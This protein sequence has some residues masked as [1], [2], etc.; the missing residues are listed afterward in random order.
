[1]S[2]LDLSKFLTESTSPHQALIAQTRGLVS[3]WKPSGLL[4]GLSTEREV[5][6]MAVLLENQANQLISEETKTSQTGAGEE[7][8]GVALPLVRK[9]F[10]E[11]AAKEFLSVQ[12]MNL[13]S[14]LVF[15]LEFKYGT[16]KPGTGY[17]NTRTQ[18]DSLYGITSGSTVVPQ[19]GLYGTGQYG[20]SMNEVTSSA[21]AIT[22]ASAAGYAAL[23]SSVG[24]N[25]SPANLWVYAI[26]TSALTTP[27]LNAV[28]SF[29]YSGSTNGSASVTG[30]LH[31]YTFVSS[32]GGV[33]YIYVVGNTGGGI[34]T[35]VAYTKQPTSSTRGDFE[36]RVGSS[37][38]PA[39]VNLNI[40]QIDLELRNESI[41]AKTRKLKA[42][43]TPEMAQDLNAYHAVDA[44]AELTALLSEYISLEIDLELLDMLITNAQTVDYWST[45]I[46]RIYNSS[47][48][49]F[50]NDTNIS[51]Q[52]WTNMT[53]YQTLGQ[54][55]QK[56]SNIIHKLTMRGGANFVVV[57]P[58]IATILEVIP[59]F[60][61]NTNGEKMQFAAGVSA[62]GSY[63]NRYTVY[64][65][66]YMTSNIVLLGF[67]GT[68]FLE[69]GAVFAPYVP[70]IMTPLVYD[71][72]NFTPRRGVMTRYAKKMLRPEFYGKI[73]IENLALI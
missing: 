51:G 20:Y 24:F 6:N 67:R 55:I 16:T 70:L 73:Y 44:E 58:D 43:W 2:K 17:D 14:G 3:K 21:V 66:P 28:R 71:P 65:N 68:Q 41:T 39:G 61:A 23:S 4:E 52:A 60:T 34:I 13:P 54:K 8:N 5:S 46:G 63:Q 72:E 15:Y 62:V 38:P 25:V 37:I 30:I 22:T 45:S 32:S 53:W 50:V 56:V 59:G 10:G 64:K 7:W 48:G 26:P 33:Q 27:D 42:V 69:T 57:S 31:D 18:G 9:V 49:G 19:G 40:P 1:M 11:I 36:D 35:S 29:Q 47:T 12:P